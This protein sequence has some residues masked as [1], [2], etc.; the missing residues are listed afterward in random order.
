[1]AVYNIACNTVSGVSA[2]LN[3]TK[4]K[5]LS[6]VAVYYAVSSTSTPVAYTTGNCS[7]IPANTIRD[8]NCGPG[9]LVID[10]NTKT[11]ISGVGPQIAFI[12]ATGAPAGVNVTEIGWVDFTKVTN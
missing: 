6:N 8:I 9:N 3:S 1:M 11:V 5:V 10:A 7:L 12:S 2:T 4:V